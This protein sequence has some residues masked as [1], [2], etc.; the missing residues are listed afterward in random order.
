[1]RLFPG[2]H[3]ISG[4]PLQRCLR[5]RIQLPCPALPPGTLPLVESCAPSVSLSVP[6]PSG[7]LVDRALLRPWSS[8]SPVLEE[9][10]DTV[11]SCRLEHLAIHSWVFTLLQGFTG[12]HPSVASVRVTALSVSTLS[13][14]WGF[15]PY[16][17][18]Q[19]K[20]SESRGSHPPARCVFRVRTSLDALLPF[21]PSSHF[22]PGRSWDCHLQGFSL[23]NG[24]RV[25]R[26][27]RALLTLSDPTTA[28]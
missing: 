27:P 1:M 18:R 21:E 12:D 3:Q 28:C 7:V 2:S 6:R 23:P 14:S 10:P 25:F 15:D 11:P 16:S 5:Q 8:R 26:R 4:S 9:S 13:L 24:P 22:W 19:L 17:D 20:G